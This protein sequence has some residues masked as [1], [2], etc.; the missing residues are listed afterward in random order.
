[1]FFFG[2]LICLCIYL[3]IYFTKPSQLRTAHTWV[4][5][6]SDK[7]K[8]SQLKLSAYCACIF[9]I[10][11]YTYICIYIFSIYF[12]MDHTHSQAHTDA[13]TTQAEIFGNGNKNQGGEGETFENEFGKLQKI[14]PPCVRSCC[15]F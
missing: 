10:Y 7:W 5:F 14:S 3:D 1:M 6:Q 4:V 11:S 2:L 12:Y 13:H 15:C 8:V 9:Y